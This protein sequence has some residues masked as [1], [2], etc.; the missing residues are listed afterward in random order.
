MIGATAILTG[1]TL[2]G[3]MKKSDAKRFEE[4]F[5]FYF[6]RKRPNGKR[7]FKEDTNY[8]QQLAAAYYQQAVGNVYPSDFKAL[9]TW[10]STEE[11]YFVD[12][13]KFRH[14]VYEW[15]RRRKE[16]K[17]DVEIDEEFL[18]Y[19]L[20]YACLADMVHLKESRGVK[21]CPYRRISIL[22]D[23]I[24]VR[25]I[26]NSFLGKT[27]TECFQAFFN[28]LQDRGISAEV[29]ERME[30]EMREADDELTEARASGSV[31]NYYLKKM[32]PSIR[33]LVLKA[34]GYEPKRQQTGRR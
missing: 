29:I 9:F 3:T 4:E 13:H 15:S 25:P 11:P 21:D 30:K 7:E 28:L 12:E 27:K 17:A 32:H 33:G 22:C 14:R 18:Q 5:I 2:G 20:R 19:V 8:V 10:L 24:D 16:I 26:K 23:N 31:P 34:M 6:C 1:A